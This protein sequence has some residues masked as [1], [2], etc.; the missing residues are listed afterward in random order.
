MTTFTPINGPIRVVPVPNVPA[1]YLAVDRMGIFLASGR[2]MALR[3]MADA[4]NAQHFPE[5]PG[6]L[7]L[8]WAIS[9]TAC[10]QCGFP[11]EDEEQEKCLSC[12]NPPPVVV[13]E[14]VA[15]KKV[16]QQ[17]EWF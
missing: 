11:K 4:F 7:R 8:P 3:P 2:E 5:K 17:S 16:E 13:K 15:D 9:V 6:E 1:L 12:L 14:E 10:S